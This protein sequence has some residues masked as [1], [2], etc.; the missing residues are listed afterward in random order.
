MWKW[1]PV[2]A[3]VCEEVHAVVLDVRRAV[4]DEGGELLVEESCKEVEAELRHLC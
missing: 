1:R 2:Y 3:I 4:V